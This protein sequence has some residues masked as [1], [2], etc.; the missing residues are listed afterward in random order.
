MR[1]IFLH[2]ALLAAIVLVAC[3]FE[4]D[5]RI[6]HVQRVFMHDDDEYSFLVRDPRTGEMRTRKFYANSVRFVRDVPANEEMWVEFHDTGGCE[7]SH[8][9]NAT[10]TVHLHNAAE[11]EGAGW[12]RGK[13]GQG[14]THPIE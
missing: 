6:D 4:A 1:K 10:I 11:V 8:G 7:S 3:T 12:D 14:M 2:P 9:N 5:E 13:G